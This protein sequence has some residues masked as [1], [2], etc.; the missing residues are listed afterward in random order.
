MGKYLVIE[1]LEFYKGFVLIWE[2][3][4]KFNEIRLDVKRDDI[5]KIWINN[6]CFSDNCDV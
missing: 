2:C 3:R 1:I 4:L 6:D 5:C